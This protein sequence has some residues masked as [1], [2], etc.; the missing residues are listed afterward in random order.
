MKT[1]IIARHGQRLGRDLSPV[2]R[3]GMNAL[4][5]R[6]RAVLPD[7]TVLVLSSPEPAALESARLLA[8][9]FD[10]KS[11]QCPILESGGEKVEDVP[12]A[13]RLILEK[14]ALADVLILV[15]H[16]EYCMALPW[17][18]LDQQGV[19]EPAVE[20]LANAQATVI[21]YQTLTARVVAP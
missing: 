3:A 13:Y 10:V 2:G 21:D 9:I 12:R 6:L 11:E 15:T 16:S 1:L 19:A 18:F 4:A 14:S 8:S 7:G 5:L 20:R 17:H